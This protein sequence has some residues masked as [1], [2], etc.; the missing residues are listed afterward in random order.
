VSKGNGPP[1][2]GPASSPRRIAITGATGFIGGAVAAA[3]TRT[4]WGVRALVRSPSKA[5]SLARLGVDSIP[6][7][8]SD[9]EALRTLVGDADAVVHCAGSV[10][11]IT[12]ADFARVNVVGLERVASVAASVNPPP[13]FISLSSLAARE[14]QLSAYAASKRAGEDALARAAGTMRWI[15]LRPPAVYG[16]GDREMLPLLLSMMRGFAPVL[17]SSEARIS[18]LYVEDLVA[19]IQRCLAAAPGA[20]GRF[21]L[22]D[23]RVGGYS[24][25]E[26]VEA[27]IP[28][29]GRPIRPIRVPTSLLRG[30]SRVSLAW[31]RLTGNAPML[32]PGKVRELTH[33]DWVCDN[34]RFTN[35]TGWTPRF[36]FADGLERTLAW[37]RSG[38]MSAAH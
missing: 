33:T 27:A 29:R 11:G 8:L 17:G 37:H 2:P 3:L 12:E 32:T 21:E 13:L 22:H 9:T 10:R 20:R 18:L 28:L 19:A 7:D 4:G 31:A 23:G 30:V 34:A 36:G 25:D 6:G 14:P 15:A 26:I 1:G 5:E 16:P 35:A 38:K 24:W